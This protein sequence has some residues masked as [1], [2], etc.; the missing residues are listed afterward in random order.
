MHTTT[1]KIIIVLITVTAI[2]TVTVGVFMWRA[3]ANR[4]SV[5]G[6]IVRFLRGER[7]MEQDLNDWLR[8]FGRCLLWR[9]FSRGVQRH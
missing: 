6:H 3:H 5:P 4:R 8:I 7:G 1:K 9:S 2:L